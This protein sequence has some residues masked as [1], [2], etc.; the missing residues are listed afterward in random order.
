MFGLWG[1]KK[2]RLIRESDQIYAQRAVA[3]AA[4]ARCARASTLPTLITSFYPASLRRIAGPLAA[5]GIV[6]QV[7]KAGS[8]ARF[9]AP[10]AWL[11]D[12]QR[13]TVDPGLGSALMSG[14]SSLRVLFVEHFASLATE[15]A[16]LAVLEEASAVTPLHVRFFVG[17]DEPLMQAFNGARI[18]ALMQQL[19]LGPEEAIEH[20]FVDRA[21]A[22]AQR[23]LARHTVS[24]Q[25]ADSDAEWFRLNG[26]GRE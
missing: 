3:D 4:L 16:A 7:P 10:G 1:K 17:L 12:A 25:P 8:S 24:F 22:N 13:L 21:I 2:S 5:E 9:D 14:G 23:K 19:G 20:P 11:L 15:T 18:V 6:G 26:L